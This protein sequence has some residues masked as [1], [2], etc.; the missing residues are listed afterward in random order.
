MEPADKLKILEKYG[1]VTITECGIPFSDTGKL[2]EYRIELE[3]TDGILMPRGSFMRTGC[4]R[5]N[6]IE[7]MYIYIFNHILEV[8]YTL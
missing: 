3:N 7:R 4:T 5:D 6:A 1:K 8:V 2:Y